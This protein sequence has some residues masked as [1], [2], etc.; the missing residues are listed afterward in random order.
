[1]FTVAV[2]DY[3]CLQSESMSAQEFVIKQRIRLL[4]ALCITGSTEPLEKV[5]DVL[6]AQGELTWEDYHS[7]LVPGSPLYKNAR[8]LLDLVYIK[9]SDTCSLFLSAVKQVWPDVQESGLSLPQCSSNVK[10]R[11]DSQ[12]TSAHTLLTR[13]ISLV[14][15]LQ[16][17]LDI[18]LEAL[19]ESGHFTAAEC[20]EVRLPTHTPSQQVQ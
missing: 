9:G 11:E 19:L 20:D 15:V 1:M 7:V 10:V 12:C 5:L 18:T 14:N 8:Q 16:G 13:R 6:L 3:G 2:C 4:D 17:C